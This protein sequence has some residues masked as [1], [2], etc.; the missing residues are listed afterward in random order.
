MAGAYLLLGI[1]GEPT[2]LKKMHEQT[3]KTGGTSART[4]RRRSQHRTVENLDK[5]T[6]AGRRARQLLV[7]FETELGGNLTDG[8]RLAVSRAAV[9][10]A[11]AEDA[12]VRKLGG[13]K[14]V[15]LDDL[16]R[17]DRVAAMAV[18]A[19]GIGVRKR[20]AAPALTLRSYLNALGD[21]GGGGGTNSAPVVVPKAVGARS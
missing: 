11:I 9:M 19:L 6:T 14:D 18:K 2:G 13:A 4:R 5:R 17:L 7:Q 1:T 16:V 20:D 12:R 3:A 15:S 21:P 8:L 10:T